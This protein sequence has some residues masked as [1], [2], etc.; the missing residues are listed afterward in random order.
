[1][2]RPGRGPGGP[3]LASLLLVPAETL[4]SPPGAGHDPDAAALVG[5]FL[6]A[7]AGKL[8]T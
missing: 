8:G 1:V 5:A 3:A 7:S 2:W 6:T 4:Q